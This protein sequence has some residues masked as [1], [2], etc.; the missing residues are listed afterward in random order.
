MNIM[1]RSSIILAFAVVVL[2][3]FA[4]SSTNSITETSSSIVGTWKWLH[5]DQQGVP[6]PFYLRFYANGTVASWEAHGGVH[7]T[8]NG[9]SYHNYHFDGSLLVMT[10]RDKDESK[11]KVEI[12]GDEMVRMIESEGHRFIYHRI[13]PDI[14]PGTWPDAALGPATNA[15]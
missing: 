6:C 13:V 4:Q 7:L 8:T 11:Y 5:E 14:Q 2:A 10:V 9:V 3:G 15:H 1:R 12:H